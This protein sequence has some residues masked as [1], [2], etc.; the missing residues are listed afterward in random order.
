LLGFSLD[1]RYADWVDKEVKVDSKDPKSTPQQMKEDSER[2]K[3]LQAIYHTFALRLV[4]FLHLAAILGAVLMFW[5]NQ[6]GAHRPL[7]KL[8]LRW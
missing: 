6:R 4:V 8:E 3:R 2:G 7:P 1:N 5:I